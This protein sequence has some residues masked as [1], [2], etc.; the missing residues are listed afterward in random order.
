[1]TLTLADFTLELTKYNKL[2]TEYWN[3]NVKHPAKYIS[4]T[5]TKS[6]SGNVKC[7]FLILSLSL[8]PNKAINNPL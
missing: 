1:M 3:S 2:K 6:F 7:F 5:K 4:I 8:V